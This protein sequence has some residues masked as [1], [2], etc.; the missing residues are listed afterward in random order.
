MEEGRSGR[1]R[2]VTMTR[3]ML[4]KDAE[5]NDIHIFIQG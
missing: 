5:I 3:E 2:N 4:S 1:S